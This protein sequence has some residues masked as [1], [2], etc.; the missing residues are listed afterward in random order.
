MTVPQRSGS[1]SCRTKFE[2]TRAVRR[3]PWYLLCSF[4][5]SLLFTASF[6]SQEEHRADVNLHAQAGL[7]CKLLEGAEAWPA[8]E[9]LVSDGL[10]LD[11]CP[12]DRFKFEVVLGLWFEPLPRCDRGTRL[13]NCRLPLRLKSGNP[14]G[15]MC[16]LM[17]KIRRTIPSPTC[18]LWKHLKAADA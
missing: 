15:R 1:Q 14:T 13:P 16:F 8:P 18:R 17:R 10:A 9:Q 4:P 11:G 3:F 5:A 12:R 6:L 7:V 2:V